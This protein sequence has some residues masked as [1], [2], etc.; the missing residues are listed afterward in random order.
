M[1]LA[2]SQTEDLLKQLD[3]LGNM[4]VFNVLNHLLESFDEPRR[5]RFDVAARWNPAHLAELQLRRLGK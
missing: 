1:P 4:L 2:R 3:R 5:I